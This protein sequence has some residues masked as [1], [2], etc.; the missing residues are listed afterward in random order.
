MVGGAG[1][2]HAA[3][4]VHRHVDDDRTGPHQLQLFAADQLG[5]GGAGDEHRADHEVRVRDLLLDG[6]SSGEHGLDV[7]IEQFVQLL[8]AVDGQVHHRDVRAQ[9]QHHAAGVGANKAA[10]QDHNLGLAHARHARDQDASA[11]EGL[12]QALRALDGG[13]P[14]GDLAHRL[15]QRKLPLPVPQGFVGDALRAGLY[16]RV[17]QLAVCGQVQIRIEDLAPSHA[18]VFRRER[19]FDLDEHVALG[20]H[21]LGV[22]QGCTGLP[23]FLVGKAAALAQTLLH[24][25][26]MPVPHVFRGVGGR[27]S[28]PEFALLDLLDA[29]DGHMHTPP[30]LTICSRESPFAASRAR[31]RTVARA[32]TRRM[33]RR[34]PTGKKFDESGNFP[35]P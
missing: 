34:T 31:S 22:G 24:Q 19:L 15:E 18:G 32:K 1:G 14:P 16:E 4:L 3:A 33:P 7:A 9:A 11:A 21:A 26:P 12:F 6:G 27:H 25:H 23:V 17:G 20:P 2:F 8:Q 29:P 30:A 10:A 28:H 13:Q 35:V 5:R